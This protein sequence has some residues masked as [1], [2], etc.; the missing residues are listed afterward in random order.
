MDDAKVGLHHWSDF[1]RIAFVAGNGVERAAVQAFGFLMPSEV[2][3]FSL[4][5]LDAARAWIAS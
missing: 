5:D 3:A 2:K 1:E 4:G